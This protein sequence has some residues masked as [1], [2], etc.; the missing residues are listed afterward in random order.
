MAA[1]PVCKNECSEPPVWTVSDR[2][3][4]QHFVLAEESAE[5]HRKLRS[6]IGALWGR[7]TC[8]LM[9][10]GQCELSFAWPFVAGDG[11]FY[12]LA[13]PHSAYPE[14]RWEFE[15]TLSV[16]QVQPPEGHVLEIG[17]GFGHFLRRV[18]PTFVSR[19]RVV[20]VEYNDRARRRLLDQGFLALAEDFRSVAFDKYKG[21]LG[22]VFLFQVLEHMD[23][24]DEAVSRLN[25]LLRPGASLFIAVPNRHLIDFNEA[26]GALIDMPPNHISRWSEASFRAL[27]KRAGWT[28]VD[29]R[30][31]PFRWQK[32]LATDAVYA[33]MRRAQAGGSLANRVRSWPRSKVRRAVEF[34]LAAARS[35]LRLPAWLAA[36]R[37]GEP[38]GESVWVHL[39]A[40]D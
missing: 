32:F 4:A 28:T 33:H 2:E 24:L 30:V 10:C 35:P 13:Y 9:N 12:N 22:A 29:F 16:L 5:I 17:S 3:A 19:D 21:Q 23:R 8:E 39:R 38:L 37:S 36:A 20:A 26:H 40:A 14:A 18:S 25:E 27:A 34:G 31:Q 15:Q 11:A 7:D 1:C 6:H